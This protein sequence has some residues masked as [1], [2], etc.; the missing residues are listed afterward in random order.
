ML[1]VGISLAFNLIGVLFDTFIVITSVFVSLMLRPI[2]LAYC[3]RRLF[4]AVC[5]GMCVTAR[6][7][8]QQSQDLLKWY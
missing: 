3:E 5:V 6:L 4:F 1:V 2:Y 7:C 8:H